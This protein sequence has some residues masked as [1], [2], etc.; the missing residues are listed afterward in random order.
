[1]GKNLIQQ[2][3]GRGTPRYKSPGHR[4]LGKVS[5]TFI[6]QNKNGIVADIVDAPG[7]HA[8]VAVVDFSGKKVLHLAAEGMHVGQEINFSSLTDGNIL[9]L[10]KIPEG[11]KVCN[12]E[13]HPGDGGKMCRS[14]GTF[15]TLLTKEAKNIIL[16]MPSNEKKVISS[17]CRA[18]FGS[19]AGSGRVEKPFMKAGKKF[20]AVRTPNRLWP[21]GRGVAMNAVDHPFGGQT[22]PGKPKT[23]S[24]DMPPGKKVGSISP[25]RTGRKK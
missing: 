9:E 3:R 22:R 16:L 5:Y 13:L 4:F 19:I 1:M 8:P 10:E 21:R 20:Y 11:S 7:R 12:I 14:S 24:R 6:P 18:T 23:V 25:R 17:K 15:A 2:R